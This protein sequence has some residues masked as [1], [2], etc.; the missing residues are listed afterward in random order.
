MTKRAT[1]RV[2]LIDDEEDARAT[3]R[4]ILEIEGFE[5]VEAADGC[6][7][8]NHFSRGQFDVIMV[9]MSM[10]GKNGLETIKEIRARNLDVKIIAISG[11]DWNETVTKLARE[12]GAD[13]FVEKP[14]DFDYVIGCINEVLLEKKV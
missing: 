11:I 9:D 3:F 4:E 14:I 10:P 8:L 2:L 12:C 1:T 7:G 13:C 6:E 5:V